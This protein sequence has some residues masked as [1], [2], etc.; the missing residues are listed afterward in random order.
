[1]NQVASLLPV[2]GAS[3][4]IAGGNLVGPV[5]AKTYDATISSAT[6]ITLA[7]TTTS[8][9]ILAI[10]QAVIVRFASTVST[11]DFDAVVGANTSKVFWRDPAV[12]TISV[13]QAAATGA[14][15]VIE[16]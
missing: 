5:I 2:D 13:I 6:D 3:K 16:R 9:E 14:V 4:V 1:M 10:T 11:T 15:A 8:F 12:T 7:A